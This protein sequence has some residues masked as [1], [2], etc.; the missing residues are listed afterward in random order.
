[1]VLVSISS[2]SFICLIFCL[3]L[4]GSVRD[5]MAARVFCKLSHAFEVYLS[6]GTGLGLG[7]LQDV[8]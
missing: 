7:L 2:S 8:P 1:M 5:V 4:D 3:P 6:A